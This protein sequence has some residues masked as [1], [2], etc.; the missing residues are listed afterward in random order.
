MKKSRMPTLEVYLDAAASIL[1]IGRSGTVAG[2][3]ARIHDLEQGLYH[4]GE[5]CALDHYKMNYHPL[6]NAHSDLEA[7]RDD[8]HAVGS[9]MHSALESC[10]ELSSWDPIYTGECKERNRINH[11]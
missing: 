7:L 9:L 8:W 3:L 5:L 4:S 6:S 10:S 1:D 2:E 11:D